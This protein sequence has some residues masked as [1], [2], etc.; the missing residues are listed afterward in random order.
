MN[1]LIVRP[2]KKS[3]IST[4]IVIDALDECRDEEPTSA[5]LTVLGQLV[6]E[7][8]KVKFFVTG[9]PDPRILEGFRLLLLAKTAEVFPLHGVEQ[10]EVDSD[11]RLFLRRSFSELARRRH[12]LDNWPTNEQLD[13]LCK[14][15]AGL[16][17]HA[18][19]TVKFIDH[20]NETPKNQLALLLQLP[21]NHAYEGM[22][23]FK[24]NTT[25]DSLYLLIL[26][27]AFGDDNSEYDPKVRSILG[28]V[29]LSASPL[30]PCAIATLL[31]FDIDGVRL[32][33]SSI[34]SLLI[35][36][37]VNSPVWPFHRSFPEFV[38]DPTRC[39]NKRFCVSHPSHNSE[40]L[41]GCLKLMNRTLEKNMC[42]LPNAI[43]N[44]EVDDLHERTERYISPALRYACKSWH[45]HFV[46]E[47]TTHTPA[48]RSDLHLFL[49]KKFLFWLEVLSVLG[50]VREAVDALEMAAKRLE[51][52]RVSVLHVLPKFTQTGYRRLRL[53]T[54]STTASV[55]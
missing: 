28:A 40:L 27:E 18:A 7:I 10:W 31:D 43:T 23:R 53:L 42:G 15:A 17:V 39:I 29:A 32:R 41:V 9:R 25:L 50:A 13:L 55:S 44:S 20:K 37:D 26:Q 33:L 4:V 35:L 5:I 49:E 8:P 6:S 36:E 11:I 14:R 3:D 19:A 16:F 21:E 2:L 1:K 51:V 38:V 34:H 48:I 12:E 54:S 46:D 30:S 52:C 45:K 22:T 47:H 24:S